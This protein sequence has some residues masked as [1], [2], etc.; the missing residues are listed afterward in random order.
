MMDEI[1]KEMTANQDDGMSAAAKKLLLRWANR[2]IFSE[3]PLSLKQK[4]NSATDAVSEGDND[5]TAS[6][7]GAEPEHA[8]KLKELKAEGKQLEEALR[9]EDTR[10]GAEQVGLKKDNAPSAQVAAAKAEHDD[11][12]SG[13]QAMLKKNADDTNRLNKGGT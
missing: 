7:T 3:K 11:K 9:H 13:L 4:F 12:V 5:A 10:W 8:E 1:E 6:K 2:D